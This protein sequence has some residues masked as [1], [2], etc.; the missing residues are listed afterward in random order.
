MPNKEVAEIVDCHENIVAQKC[1]ELG[2]EAWQS[3]NYDPLKIFSKHVA[4]DVKHVLQR[5]EAVGPERFAALGTLPDRVVAKIF[6]LS[7]KTIWKDRQI[8]GIPAWQSQ[9]EPV[10]TSGPLIRVHRIKEL[11]NTF[12]DEQWQ[13]A[14]SFFS[15]RCAYCN[16]KENFL[17]ALT[18]DHLVPVV[19]GGPR[20]VMNIVPACKRCNSSKGTKQAPEWIYEKFGREQ[21]AKIINQIVAY[22]ESRRH[23]D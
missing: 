1:W 5:L 9:R 18:E 15:E 14:R 6:D 16:Q 3:P 22:L 13:E 11:P 4:R 23:H 17:N 10:A 21:G 12:T 20:T 2:I 19:H 8:F 7:L